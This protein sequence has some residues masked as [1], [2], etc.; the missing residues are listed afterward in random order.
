MVLGK[1]NLEA[2][3]FLVLSAIEELTIPKGWA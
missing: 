1:A 2:F 3:A